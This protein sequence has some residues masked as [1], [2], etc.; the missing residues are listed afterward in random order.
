MSRDKLAEG[1]PYALPLR[2]DGQIVQTQQKLSEDHVPVQ[3]PF[4]ASRNAAHASLTV[5]AAS[6]KA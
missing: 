2:G 3:L 5:D 4:A 1:L 6:Q